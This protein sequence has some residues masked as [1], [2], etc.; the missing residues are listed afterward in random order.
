M[1]AVEEITKY[2]TSNGMEFEEEEEAI[3]HEIEFVVKE[4]DPCDIILKNRFGEI[5]ELT[6]L[7]RSI[8]SAYYVEVKT[9]AALDFFNEASAAE[10][11]APLEDGLGIYRYK[12]ED[13]RWTTPRDDAQRLWE[14]WSTYNEDIKFTVS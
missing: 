10:G 11:L 5:I 13:D 4:I 7:W 1:L 12:E 6:N 14:Q 3:T 9:A 2:R 8:S